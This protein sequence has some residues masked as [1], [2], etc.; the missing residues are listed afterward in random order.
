MATAPGAQM[1]PQMLHARFG[2]SLRSTD[3]SIP[4]TMPV[5]A[6]SAQ[7]RAIGRYFQCAFV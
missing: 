1:A 7:A 4:N 3:R 5:N 6:A 2:E